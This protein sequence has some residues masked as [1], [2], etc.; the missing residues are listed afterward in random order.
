MSIE[1][2]MPSN[3]LILCH[4]LLLLPSIFP[5]SGSFPRNQFFGS[6]GQSIG[7]SAS[8]SVPPMNIQDWL[9]LGWTGWTSL[10]SKGLSRVFSNTWFYAPFPIWKQPVVPCPVLTVASWAAYR[11]LRGQIRWSGIPISLRIFHSLLWATQSKA[12][13]WSI[14]QK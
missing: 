7:A 13:A 8:A 11:F 3:H 5:G 4:L 6:G 1:S 12:L 10:L 9:P 2:V 14:K